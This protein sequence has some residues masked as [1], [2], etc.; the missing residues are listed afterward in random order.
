MSLKKKLQKILYPQQNSG[1][2]IFIAGTIGALIG[3]AIASLTNK[4]TGKQ[5]RTIIKSTLNKVGEETIK[6]SSELQ[7]RLNS[8]SSDI[9]NKFEELQTTIHNKV[10]KAE[11]KSTIV[12]NKA[13]EL[14]D[15]MAD[16]VEEI[17]K[18]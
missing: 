8:L 5:N 14:K 4:N 15:E 11:E 6:S 1:K 3:G 9:L 16:S 2:K 18:A 10:D 13:K 17:K 7:K 12:K